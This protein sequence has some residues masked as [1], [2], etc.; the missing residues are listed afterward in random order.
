MNWVENLMVMLIQKWGVAIFFSTIPVL[1]DDY[2]G[3]DDYA[4]IDQD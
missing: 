2:D 3:D 1:C 4:I